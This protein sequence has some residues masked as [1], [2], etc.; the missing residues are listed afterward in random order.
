[1]KRTYILNVIEQGLS[2]MVPPVD[3]QGHVKETDSFSNDYGMDSLDI[4]ELFMFMEDKLKKDLSLEHFWNCE[5]VG[6]LI[7]NILIKK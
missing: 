4:Y 7:D 6:N 5:T 2:K 3:I 1:M